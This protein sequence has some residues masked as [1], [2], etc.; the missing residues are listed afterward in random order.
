MDLQ[1][2]ENS[3]VKKRRKTIPDTSKS[4]WSSDTNDDK[5]RMP[6]NKYIEQFKFESIK[7]IFIIISSNKNTTLNANL[8]Y[9]NN[10]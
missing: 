4:D 8:L 1:K 9:L 10:I 2:T 3:R 6:Y 5:T 7:N